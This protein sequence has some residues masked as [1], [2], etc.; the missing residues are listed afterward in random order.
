MPGLVRCR[1]SFQIASN[2]GGFLDRAGEHRA[3][4]AGFEHQQSANR[5]TSTRRYVVSAAGWRPVA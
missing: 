3:D 5:A 1:T 4:L 2:F